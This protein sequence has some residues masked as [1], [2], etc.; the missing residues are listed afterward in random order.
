M[1]QCTPAA[2]IL[3]SSCLTPTT[4]SSFRR[5]VML[6]IFTFCCAIQ[7]FIGC[8]HMYPTSWAKLFFYLPVILSSFFS[9]DCSLSHKLYKN[10]SSSSEN[11]YE[12]WQ[13]GRFVFQ[14]RNSREKLCVPRWTQSS[15]FL[16]TCTPTYVRYAGHASKY[17]DR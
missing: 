10:A 14:I 4:Y 17:G 5:D 16:V 1:Q 12:L 2:T 9:V 11:F 15:H 6:A 3:T 7:S 13:D 8:G